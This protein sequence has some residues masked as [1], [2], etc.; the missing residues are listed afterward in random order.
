M[1]REWLNL[2]IKCQ[3]DDHMICRRAVDF[4]FMLWENMDNLSINEGQG[5][6]TGEIHEINWYSRVMRESMCI[7][8]GN[9][10]KHYSHYTHEG[11]C[12]PY[13]HHKYRKGN[14]PSDIPLVVWTSEFVPPIY[15]SKMSPRTLKMDNIWLRNKSN[16]TMLT[17]IVDL[18]EYY[19]IKFNS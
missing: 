8:N 18:A 13:N 11:W 10:G 1:V 14:K 19:C 6:S 12:L 2:E 3:W 16:C 7:A 9:F 15:P 4:A 17:K 5:A